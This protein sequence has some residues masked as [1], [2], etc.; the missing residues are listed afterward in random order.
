MLRFKV[1]TFF[2]VQKFKEKFALQRI[3]SVLVIDISRI[4]ID[5]CRG[6]SIMTQINITFWY[7]H[8]HLSQPCLTF[9]L[10][11]VLV[12]LLDYDHICACLLKYNVHISWKQYQINHLG[13]R[14]YKF[15]GEW[16]HGNL[17]VMYYISCGWEHTKW[18]KRR[19]MEI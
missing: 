9:F 19:K 1:K 16:I 12:G 3:L 4:K 6:I 13:P 2:S 14:A 5:L 8:L 18:N 11:L 17:L 10:F 15:T 7:I